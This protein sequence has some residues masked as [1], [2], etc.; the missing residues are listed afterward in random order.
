[1]RQGC[2]EDQEPT[3]R[4]N[5]LG[6][7]SLTP[8][9]A[10]K[11]QAYLFLAAGLLGALGVFLPHPDRFH[12]QGMLAVQISSVAA[13]A[14]L[15]AFHEKSP[16]WFTRVG[17]YGAATATSVVLLFSGRATSAYLLFYL[18]VAFYAFYFLSRREAIA[19]ATFTILSYAVVTSA[20]RIGGFGATGV[21]VNEDIPALVLMAGTVFVAGAFIVLLRE[22]VGR[23]IRQLGDAASTDPLTGLLS[24]RGFHHAVETELARSGRSD[25]C[26][27]VVL[28]DCDFFKHL[29][30]RLGHNSG[31]E[32]LVAIGWLLEGDRRRFDVA[33]RIGGEEF[34]VMLPETDQ[35][36]AYVVAERLRT[37][38]SQAFADQ[39]EQL[40]MSFGV[41]TYPAHAAT[42]DGLL[43]AADDAL[44][45]AKALGRDRCV[46]HS[47]EIAGILSAD[48][49]A[50]NPR[51][52]AQLATVLNLAEALDMRDTG[53]ARHSQTVGRYCEL[54][55]RALGLTREQIDRVR[56]AGVL[57]DI[58][59]IGVSDSILCKPGP[60]T[61]E[62]YEAMKKHPETGARILGGSGLDDIRG[63]ILAHHERPDGHGYPYGLTGDD[64]PLQARILAVG[65]AYE[66]MTSDRV[67]RRAIGAE[68]ARRELL[69]NAGK[70]FDARVVEAF[71]AALDQRVISDAAAA[72]IAA[73]R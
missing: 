24:R 41:A 23:L 37:R 69:D 31:D 13:G 17:P 28:G 46:L 22:R 33:A 42:D 1:M 18:W 19:L 51:D 63:W 50:M 5:A 4:E 35:H 62:E 55:A 45:A 66:A 11:A 34:A 53:T 72:S 16:E 56:V 25:Q 6:V 59:K 73:A 2:P 60:L 54:M 12:E 43:R 58:G 68:A 26:F 48:R 64:I 9:L 8:E 10:A 32:A 39:P 36:E 47:P 27:S 65:D 57:H 52:Q 71:L 70:Q 21:Q 14:L 3:L 40:T 49:D 61:G 44:Y 30:D 29:N 20:F 15:F 67:Y 7:R 38:I